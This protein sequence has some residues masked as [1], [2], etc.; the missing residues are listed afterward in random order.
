MENCWSIFHPN[1]NSLLGKKTVGDAAKG[2]FVF[3]ETK[4]QSSSY[5]RESYYLIV[6]NEICLQFFS[7]LIR[8]TNLMSLVNPC[9]AIVMLL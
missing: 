6:L 3:P 8:E 7:L 4:V 9:F 2:L 5:Q 1:I